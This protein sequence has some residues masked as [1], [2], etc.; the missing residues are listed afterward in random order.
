MLTP[1]DIGIDL[2][3]DSPDMTPERAST[4][5]PTESEVDL[6]AQ[7]NAALTKDDTSVRFGLRR[8]AGIHYCLMDTNQGQRLFALPWFKT[9]D[10]KATP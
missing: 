3:E 10:R 5:L 9:D 1:E 6:Q 8:L 7:I 4:A 2:E